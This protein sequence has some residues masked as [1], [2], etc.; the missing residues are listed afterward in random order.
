MRA[1][2]HT[3]LSRTGA[4][5]QTPMAANHGTGSLGARES[6]SSAR[7]TLWFCSTWCLEASEGSMRVS[8]DGGRDV[9]VDTS[10]RPFG[11]RC[12]L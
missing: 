12:P 9:D 4:A 7:V 11:S 5:G 3:S 10:F 8:E 2:P 1:T 6:S